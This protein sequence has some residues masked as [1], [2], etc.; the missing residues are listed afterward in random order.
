MS[1]NALWCTASSGKTVFL[2]DEFEGYLKTY[3][4][5]I[6][7]AGSAYAFKTDVLDAMKKTGYRLTDFW[8]A[9]GCTPNKIGGT[10][11]PI[12]HLVA[13]ETGGRLQFLRVLQRYFLT[14]RNGSHAWLATLNAK[15]SRGFTLLDYIAYLKLE[16]KYRRDEIEEEVI[17]LVKF[18]CD[19]GA[20]NA[21][22]SNICMNGGTT[23]LLQ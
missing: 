10:D 6:E 2:N 20:V 15:N 3:C 11:A 14:E 4:L 7:Q 23:F 12:A 13:E 16:N 18:V 1:S 8:H 5:K 17:K 22:Y 19:N 21:V 9:P